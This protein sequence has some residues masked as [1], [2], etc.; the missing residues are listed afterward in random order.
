ML[1]HQT[2]LKKKKLYFHHNRSAINTLEKK[3]GGKSKEIREIQTNT[4]NNI[5]ENSKYKES[6]IDFLSIDVEGYEM[7]VMNGFALEKYSPKIIVIE[8][9]DLDMKKEEF[10]NQNIEKIINSNIYKHMISKNYALVNWLH[11]DLVFI[12]KNLQDK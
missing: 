10:Y 1:Q 12:N 6:E 11:S 7:R 4:L 9:H 5:I 3:K 8:Y 2:K